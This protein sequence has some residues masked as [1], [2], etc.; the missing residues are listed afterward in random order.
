MKTNLEKW[1]FYKAQIDEATQKFLEE[2][3]IDVPSILYTV[4]NNG[5][6]VQLDVTN[7]HYFHRY[8]P[9]YKKKPTR[10]D[11]RDLIHYQLYHV[12]SIDNVIVEYTQKY[13]NVKSRGG[14]H[15][16]RLG[17]Y[18]N[19]EQAQKISNDLKKEIEHEKSLL[20]NGSHFKCAYCHKVT[21]TYEKVTQSISN[22]KMYG[23]GGKKFDYCSGRCAFSDQCAHEG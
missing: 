1:N 7:V 23:Y 3:K 18:L 17:E 12:Y 13:G 6:I 9:T 4:S 16:N 11:I 15:I 2:N 8:I 22:I 10:A 14:F 5:D 19:L 20:S 21:P